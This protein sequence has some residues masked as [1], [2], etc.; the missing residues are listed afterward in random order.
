MNRKRIRLVPQPPLHSIV[1]AYVR[2]AFWRATN[3][4]ETSINGEFTF[5]VWLLLPRY[6]VTHTTGAS[7]LRDHPTAG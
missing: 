6:G 3:L 4:V 5:R 2:D 7:S 1:T